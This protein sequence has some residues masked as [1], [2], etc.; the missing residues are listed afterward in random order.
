M[1][2]SCLSSG[3]TASH[4]AFGPGIAMTSSSR[5]A[6]LNVDAP[7]RRLV[8]AGVPQAPL[9][10]VLLIVLELP[11][12]AFGALEEAGSH[13][14]ENQGATDHERRLSPREILQILSHGADIFVPHIV[15]NLLDL[16]GDGVR[17]AGDPLLILRSEMFGGP[18]QRIG[19]ASELIGEL[20]LALAQARGCAIA[21]LLQGVFRLVHHLVLHVTDLLAGASTVLL[22]GLVGLGGAGRGVWHGHRCCSLAAL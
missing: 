9:V 6:A 8:I 2:R 16:P 13:Q 17:Q 5:D 15:G 21:S 3:I 22:S 12:S 18:A 14:T 10:T 7:G 4:S 20:I 1:L 11:A 19:D